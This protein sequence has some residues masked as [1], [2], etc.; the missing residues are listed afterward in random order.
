MKLLRFLAPLVIGASLVAAPVAH[1]DPDPPGFSDSA[2]VSG[3]G[4]IDP[5]MPCAPCHVSFSFT[6]VV[7]GDEAGLLAGCRFEGDSPVE[8]ELGGSG[9]GS[10]SGCASGTMTWYRTG[11][12]VQISGYVTLDG[13]LHVICDAVAEFSATSFAPVTS[14]AADGVV[15]LCD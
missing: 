1:A 2:V 3:T 10:L 13:E 14:F 12:F 5:G 11:S 6:A 7:S 9:S 15:V 8:T 4:T